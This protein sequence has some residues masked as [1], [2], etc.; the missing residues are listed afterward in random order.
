MHKL[1][2]HYIDGRWVAPTDAEYR[3]VIN[4]ATEEKSGEMVLGS[5]VEVNQAVAAARTAFDS[6]AF[7]TVEER[8]ALLSAIIEE[9]KKRMPEMAALITE[10]MGAPASLASA[11]HAPS[12]LG[13]LIAASKALKNYSFYED[14]GTTRV[15]K[16]VDETNET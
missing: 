1:H 12:G 11:A 16:E 13:H 14:R 8:M 2:K 15:V 6:F 9:Y 10:E 4:P 5:L 3:D 7:S